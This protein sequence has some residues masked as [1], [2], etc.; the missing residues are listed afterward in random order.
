ANRDG[1]LDAADIVVVRRMASGAATPDAAVGDTNF[2]GAVTTAD[3]PPLARALGG[4]PI[5]RMPEGVL[6]VG[7]EGGT[8]TYDN[9]TVTIPPDAFAGERALV[10]IEPMSEHPFGWN[11]VIGTGE[12]RLLSGIPEGFAKPLQVK[13]R[14]NR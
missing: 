9:I 12:M 10:R 13:V 5:A 11:G 7:R 14:D 1:V 8:V 4:A 2:D 3:V 6:N